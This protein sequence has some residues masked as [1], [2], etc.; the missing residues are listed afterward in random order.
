[1]NANRG[2]GSDN[3]SGVHPEILKAISR[4]NIGHCISYGD[5]SITG[6]ANQRFREV[7]GRQVKV[8]FV[9]TGTAANVLGIRSAAQSYNSIICARSAHLNVDECGAPENFTGCKLET[10]PSEDGKITV[11]QIEPLLELRGF[12]HHSQP[13]IISIT[14]PTE[15]GT[16]YSLDEISARADFAH[17]NGMILHMDGARLCNAAA[18][19]TC[20]LREASGDTGV[21]ILSFG[22]T[23]N[24]MLI[25]EA[26]VFFNPDL[27]REFKY[28]RKQG[29]HLASKMRYISAQFTAF[30]DK[31][32]WLQNALHAN[33]MAA[34]L[35][36]QIEKVPECRITQRVETNAVFVAIPPAVVR[37]LQ[38]RY[39]FYI[40]DRKR[41]IARF[42]TSFDT[43]M[44]DIDGLVSVMR[45]LV[46]HH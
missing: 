4:V 32:L 20:S 23:K 16:L 17:H 1:M 30:F 35:A 7:F 18:S 8:F 37:A 31:D 44:E 41:T 11:R 33:K 12:P 10:V 27:G 28:I 42:M 26:V 6:N 43:Q 29:M 15:L 25:G 14:Q 22:G 34:A 24:G 45:K 39:F 46:D 21:D 19:L 36:R 9:F 2:F 13:L 5:D 38:E 40:W 3:N